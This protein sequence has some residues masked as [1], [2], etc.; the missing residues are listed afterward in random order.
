MSVLAVVLSILLAVA[1][2][3]AGASKLAGVPAMRETAT[4]LG[5]PWP[6]YR[7]IGVLEVAGAAG[8]LIGLA[9]H[10]LGALAAICLTLLMIG[11]VAFHL[12]AKDG[13]PVFAPAVVLGVLCVVAAIAI[14]AR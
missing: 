6:R 2:V 3:G 12:R 10:A 11:A 13:P 5:I 7:S 8:L 4:H 9:V 1:F 14:L